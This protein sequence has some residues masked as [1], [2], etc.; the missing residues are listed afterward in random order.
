MS[1]NDGNRSCYIRFFP[2]I[3]R[4]KKPIF[5]FLRIGFISHAPKR[6]TLLFSDNFIKMKWLIRLRHS[7]MA[8]TL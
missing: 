2:K 6:K 1:K 4:K 5:Y 7:Q 8:L 3:T